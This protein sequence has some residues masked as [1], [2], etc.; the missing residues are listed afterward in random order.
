MILFK[1]ACKG[2]SLNQDPYLLFFSGTGRK[3]DRT[4]CLN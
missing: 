1:K 3:R 2:F 4:G